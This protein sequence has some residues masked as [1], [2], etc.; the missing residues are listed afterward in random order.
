MLM[1]IS[2][3][4]IAL[5]SAFSKSMIIPAPSIESSS[6]W[7]C[8]RILTYA[9][10]VLRVIRANYNRIGFLSNFGMNYEKHEFSFI[11]DMD[12]GATKIQFSNP[13]SIWTQDFPYFCLKQFRSVRFTSS[14]VF[15]N[16]PSHK[17]SF[18]HLDIEEKN[19]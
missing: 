9:S 4:M 6:P 11:K 12:F 16:A 10:I 17:G 13:S 19:N 15:G 18:C 14:N 7:T 2:N 8:F 5:R 3:I 1:P